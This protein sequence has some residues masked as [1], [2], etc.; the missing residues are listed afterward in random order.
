MQLQSVK[1]R[2]GST[3]PGRRGRPQAKRPLRPGYRPQVGTVE[4]VRPRHG[5]Q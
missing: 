4:V 3:V 1:G 2:S 5:P